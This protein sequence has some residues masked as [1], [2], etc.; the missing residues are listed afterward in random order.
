LLEQYAIEGMVHIT[1]GGFWENIPRVLPADLDAV[2]YKDSWPVLPLFQWLQE[3][4]NVEEYEMYRTFNMGIG[5]ML[6]VQPEI[7]PLIMQELAS[8]GEAVY[9]IGQVEKGE[10]KVRMVEA[11][12][13]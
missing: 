1:G 9:H 6:F 8:M 10:K 11:T 7:A 3:Q 2:I 12:L 13:S 5:F 4:G